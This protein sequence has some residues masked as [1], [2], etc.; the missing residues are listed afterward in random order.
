MAESTRTRWPLALPRLTGGTRCADMAARRTRFSTAIG[1]GLPWR[2]AASTPFGGQGSMGNG[3]AMRVA[4]TS[5]TRSPSDV[6][7]AVADLGNGSQVVHPDAVPFALWCAGTA[8]GGLRGSPV[9]DRVRPRRSRH[10][11]RHRRR[12]RRLARRRRGDSA[13][14]CACARTPRVDPPTSRAKPGDR[15]TWTL[16]ACRP[17]SEQCPSASLSLAPAAD[18]TCT[19]AFPSPSGSG[20]SARR[21]FWR[22]SPSPTWLRPVL[23]E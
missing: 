14:V 17:I 1:L 10:D 9:D 5:Q 2:Q 11:M 8:P 21:Y 3:S 22:T 12:R 23:D 20:A 19:R 18:S 6:A 7:V 15:L 13:R 4:G 16:S